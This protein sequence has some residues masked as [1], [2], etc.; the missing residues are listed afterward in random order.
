ME[1]LVSLVF[2]RFAIVSL[3]IAKYMKPRVTDCTMN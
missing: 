3:T 1:N 2:M